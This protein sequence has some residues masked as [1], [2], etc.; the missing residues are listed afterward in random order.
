MSK[1]LIDCKQ[2]LKKN[3]ITASSI[4]VFFAFYYSALLFTHIDTDIQAHAF[5]THKFITTG[6]SLTPN[7]L[8]FIVI[9]LF[10]GFSKYKLMYYASSVLVISLSLTA[11]FFINNKYINE[12]SAVQIEE[13]NKFK[14]VPISL[15]FIF[16]LPGLN[17]F[18]NNNFLLGQ[19]ASNLWHN[20]TVI[21]LF[22]FAIMLFFEIFSFLEKSGKSKFTLLIFLVVI[23]I[24][25]KP[26]F[27][28]TIIPTAIIWVI[29]T[30][31]Y[32]NRNLLLKVSFL[33]ILALA[34]IFM[35]YFIIYISSETVSEIDCKSCSDGVSIEPFAVWKYY[36]L[37]IPFSFISSFLFPFLYF[38]CTKGK[39]MKDNLVKFATIN[40]FFGIVIF[41]LFVETGG[42]KYHGNFG[43]QMI[44]G[45]Y[46]LFF[47][48]AIRLFTNSSEL[49]R[50]SVVYKIL[51]LSFLLHVIWGVIYFFKI[52]FLKN[53][54]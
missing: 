6:G 7:F 34:L 53:Y 30:K 43:W 23:N 27:I 33:S 3:W 11:K 48:L 45:N 36:S 37:S 51:S 54:F 15:M 13:K 28:F 19:L 25:I 1:Y 10:A 14:Y 42:R 20:S 26:S 17:F 12:F 2:F 32:N 8:Y 47:V 41:I 16:C 18:V 29:F 50:K 22:P 24:L 31:K 44:I 35:Q 21:F 4:F 46:L 9:A 52:L 5:I 40:W 38:L 49:S 39:I